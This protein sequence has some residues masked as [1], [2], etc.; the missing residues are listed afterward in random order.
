MDTY[1]EINEKCIVCEKCIEAC[2]K[3]GEGLLRLNEGGL[4]RW[5]DD[6]VMEIDPYIETK[7][8]YIPCHHCT[9]RFSKPAPCQEVC[10]QNAITITRW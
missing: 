1:I 3:D 10:E 4:Y 7:C 5:D 9:D 8:D 2:Y 6:E